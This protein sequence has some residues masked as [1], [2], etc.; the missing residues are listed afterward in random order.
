MTTVPRTSV[1]LRPAPR[2]L[3]PG[4]LAALDTGTATAR[5]TLR[6]WTVDS[7]LFGMAT[8]VWLTEWQAMPH[9]S[10]AFV[11]GWMVAVDPWVGAVACL[12]L[13]WRRRFP[14]PIA[15]ALVAALLVSN[16]ALGAVLVM[17]LTVAVH[18]GWLTAVLVTGG[19]LVPSLVF[20]FQH[21]PPG[22][23]RWPGLLLVSLIYLGPLGWGVAVRARRQLIARLRHDAERERAEHRRRLADARRAE[24]QRIAREMHDVLAHRISLIS[25]HAGALAYRTAQ[26]DAGTG[27]PLDPAEVGQAIQVISDNAR[28]G[29]TELSEVL[30][31]LRADA[32]ADSAAAPADPSTA[33]CDGELGPP[34]PGTRRV[35]PG[36]VVPQP[37]L[38]D[39]SRLVADAQSA[40]QPVTFEMDCASGVTDAL[41]PAMQRTIYRT[42][43]EGLTNARKHAPGRPVTVRVTASPATGVV[44]TVTNTLPGGDPPADAP[45]PGAGTGL[46]GLAER[47][48][49]DGGTIEHG[50]VGD[51]FRLAV[52]LPWP[53]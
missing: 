31:V 25:M 42:I 30:A 46:I 24:R 1:A 6:D 3:L 11:P 39:V 18:R 51:V 33:A 20:A 13:W 45:L 10:A 50:V 23:H 9:Y 5:R 7:L 43:Q 2:W 14:V 48:A 38:A 4:E 27:R 44:A 26:A 53:T 40:G 52:R 8:T 21:P 37:R 15:V 34:A 16:T 49:L 22:V 29:L 17:T 41:R 47:V 32:P 35:E 19:Y 28:Q 12:A 36:G